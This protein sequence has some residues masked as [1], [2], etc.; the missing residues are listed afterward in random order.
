M[1]AGSKD[2]ATFERFFIQGEYTRACQDSRIGK[3]DTF[4]RGGTIYKSVSYTHLRA[5]ET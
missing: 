5:H 1:E 2:N 3:G 4:I